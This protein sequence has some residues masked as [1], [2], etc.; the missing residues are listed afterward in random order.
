[1]NAIRYIFSTQWAITKEAL[2]VMHDI[3]A[4]TVDLQAVEAERGQPLNYTRTVSIRD[5]VAIVPIEGPIFRYANLFTSMSGATSIQILAQDFRTALHS[6]DVRA[7][8]LNVNSPGGEV[9]GTHELA[10]MIAAARGVKPITAYVSHLGC[11]AAYWLASAADEIVCDATA[12]LG[13]IGVLMAV[14]GSDGDTAIE[15]VS[16]QSPRK[17]PDPETEAGQADIQQTL[18]SLASVFISDVAA[19]RGVSVDTVLSDFGQGGVFVGA[20]A[21][22][23][24]L[25]DRLGSFESTLASLAGRDA[26]PP[27]RAASAAHTAPAPVAAASA[28]VASIH[29]RSPQET[30][31]SDKPQTPQPETP[32]QAQD[33]TPHAPPID[34]PVLAAR[35]NDY[36]AQMLAQF[37]A[38]QQALMEQAREQAQLE[39][40]KWQ[41][42]M[43]RQQAISAYV[44]DATTPK[45]DRPHAL[46]FE[47]DA[48]TAFLGSLNAEQYKAATGFFDKVLTAGLVNFEEIGSNADGESSRDTAE[49]WNAAIDAKTRGGMSKSAAISAVRKEQPELAAAYSAL[50]TKKGGR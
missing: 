48:F 22:S 29:P 20:D 35:V 30:R 43:R 31:M 40:A 10:Q 14:P 16:S 27:G 38:Q 5:G 24:G 13:S 34:D 26:A 44:Q 17:N 28:A 6:P 11:S 3:A 41:A 33:A 36:K 47:S 1:M 49:A 37:Q 8:L 9:D 21:V 25:A 2:Q 7:I 50:G 12:L 19:N 32:V 42:D 46:P 15:F 45:F 4:R 23:A 18:D 39:F